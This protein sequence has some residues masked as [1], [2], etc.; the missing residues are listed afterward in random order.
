MMG[1]ESLHCGVRAFIAGPRAWMIPVIIYLALG[2]GAALVVPSDYA[3]DPRPTPPDE[4]AHID[5]IAYLVTHRAMPVFTSGGE[6]Y[7]AHQP[8][9]Y[10]LACLPAYLLGEA[11]SADQEWLARPLIV[12]LRLFSVLLGALSIWA[13]WCL[14]R[15]FFPG[16]AGYALAVPLFL[17]LW[18]GRT[19]IVSGV[20]N[21]GLAEGLCL[22]TLVLSLHIAR[23]GLDLRRCALLGLVFALALLTKSSSMAIA[24]IL[25]IAL[26]QGASV[27]ADEEKP[28]DSRRL[29][30]AL[31]IVVL[32]VV[33]LWGWWVVRNQIL[34]GD[35]LA[36]KAFEETFAKDRATPDYFISRGFSGVQY[37]QL[38]IL[39]TFLSFWGVFGQANVYM[40]GMYYLLGTVLSIL[41]LAGWGRRLWRK[42]T[43]K[44][45]QARQAKEAQKQREKRSRGPAQPN[46]SSPF[47]DAAGVGWLLLWLLAL[48]TVALF[49][50]FNASFYQAQ[51]RYLFAAS[52]AIS[53]I[54]VTG[55]GELA[56]RKYGLYIVYGALAVML[57]MSLWA[58]AGFGFFQAED[59]IRDKAT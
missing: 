39:N 15:I 4:P 1:N 46:E 32:V 52:G 53:V 48:V 50:R 37:Y 45:A 17:A 14:G 10:Y 35:P 40:P 25:F 13:A 47:A 9:L 22:L 33:L 51:A 58:V 26:V 34:Y 21:D 57:I 49:L 30:Q 24:P 11:L 56:G 20:T 38:V 59:G 8:P 28:P 2:C 18:P 43:E 36:A 19:M 3:R 41:V 6:L 31:G 7:E 27:G 23:E 16:A 54:A 12:V 29:V 55:L 44:E 5:Y 42:K